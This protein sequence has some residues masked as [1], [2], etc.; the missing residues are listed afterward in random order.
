MADVTFPSSYLTEKLKLGDASTS[1]ALKKQLGL[2]ALTTRDVGLS[3]SFSEDRALTA[4]QSLFAFQGLRPQEMVAL[5][6][7]A[8]EQWGCSEL[9]VMVT[10][11][12]GYCRAYAQGGDVAAEVALTALKALAAKSFYLAY[13]DGP[14]SP[15]RCLYAPVLAVQKYKLRGV[16]RPTHL[17]FALTPV[18]LQGVYP[19]A[20]GFRPKP[21]DLHARIIALAGAS[22]G[23]PPEQLLRLTAWLM[24]LPK[25][26][27]VSVTD[28]TLAERLRSQTLQHSQVSKLRRTLAQH[29]EV[30]KQLGL[31][32]DFKSPVEETAGKWLIKLL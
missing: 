9:P 1:R 13:T 19:E 2:E 6:T 24:T 20:T 26:P 12:K 3:L 11:V 32:K 21:R 8:Q 29:F 30:A 22:S 16:R 23:R 27:T 31:M 5:S 28:R 15:L 25:R 4:V 14:E 10:E 18:L 7:Q 17:R